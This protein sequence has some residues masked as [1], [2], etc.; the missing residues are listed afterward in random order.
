MFTTRPDTLYGATFFV[1]APEAPLAAE[2]VG[3]AQRS[4]FE[5]YL[6]QTKRVTEIERQSTDRPKT[7]VFLGAYAVNPVNG[8][9]IPVFA[10][11]Y[12]LAE[13]GTGAVMA[14]P[15]HDQR[16]LDFA[17]TFDLPVRQVVDTGAEDPAVTGVATPGDGRYINSPS[18]EGLSDKT[19]GVAA[20]IGQ[21]ESDGV[22]AGAI[23]YRLRDWLLSRQRYWG[24]P[25]PIIHCGSCGEVPVPDDQLPVELPDLRGADLAPK[26][27]SPL[28]AA[29][30]W[31]EVELSAVRWT[32]Q[33][34]HRHDGHLRRLVVVLLPLLLPGG[35]GRTVRPRG[36]APLDAGRA[37]RR[38]QGARD[39][40]PALHAVLHQGAATTW[41]WSTSSSRCAS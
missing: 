7:G 14:V 11:D 24:C 23:T 1:V 12:V 17:R 30:D 25:I 8:E 41:A 31:V 26:G 16:D 20:I 34:G 27:I 3:A 13:Y 22:G 2:I 18:L 28:A 15:A 33:A 5:A 40:A 37:V 38:R 21:L 10:A 36:R 6:E 9:Q 32:G 4:A 35:Q 29:S 39:P 19:A